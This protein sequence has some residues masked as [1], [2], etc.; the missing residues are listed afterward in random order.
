MPHALPGSR[1][2]PTLEGVAAGVSRF[3]VS[4]VVNGSTQVRP[5]VARAVTAAI[6]RLGYIPNRAARSLA[7]RQTLSIALVVPEDTTH[8]FGDP[9]F[10]LIVQGIAKVLDDSDYVLT[11]QLVSPSSPSQK[12][13]RYLLGGQCRR[14][15][16]GLTP[17]RG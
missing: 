5:D 17:L 14:R 2:L 3:T 8:F 15:S 12:S 11:L 1:D 13:I 6:E 10:A 7:N 4:R 9:Y 16:R